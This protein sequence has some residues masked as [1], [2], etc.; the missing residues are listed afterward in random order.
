MVS[1]ENGKYI[2]SFLKKKRRY[3][4]FFKN[5]GE[6]K[7]GG[8]KFPPFLRFFFMRG[9]L[10]LFDDLNTVEPIKHPPS[11]SSPDVLDDV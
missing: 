3:K 8:K 5:W 10:N 2:G 9:Y 11:S 1:L 7:K 6:N 4:D